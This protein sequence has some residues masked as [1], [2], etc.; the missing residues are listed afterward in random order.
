MKKILLSLTILFS[1]STNA[2][3][4]SEKEIN[5]SYQKS[6][7]Y[8]KMNNFIDAVK[9]LSDVYSKYK[10]TY[11]V[12]L[13]LGWLY[14]LSGDY[15]NSIFH[16]DKAM[17]VQPYYIEAKIGYL[18]PLLMQK[19][20][21]EV[22]DTCYKILKVDY[23]NYLTNVRLSYVLRMQKKYDLAEKV[24]NKMLYLY[25]TDVTFLNELALAKYYDNKKNDAIVIFKSVLILDPENVIAKQ[26][27]KS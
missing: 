12:N 21:S 9:S 26:Y 15:A 10:D 20:Y 7:N 19:K 1:I 16:Y 2:F 13:R 4:L 3:A 11:T 25:P 27:V 5:A 23:Y 22:E 14:Y 6:Y 8:E 17:K 18:L 24:S